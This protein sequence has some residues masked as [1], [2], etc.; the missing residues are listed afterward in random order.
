MTDKEF[1]TRKQR[2]V[3]ITIAMFVFMV[4]CPIAGPLLYHDE[5]A[6][7]NATGRMVYYVV[8]VGTFLGLTLYSLWF[9]SRFV[10]THSPKKEA[11]KRPASKVD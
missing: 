9:Y 11:P 7:L 8:V 3:F 5:F 10:R 1:Q 2:L 4:S 6:R